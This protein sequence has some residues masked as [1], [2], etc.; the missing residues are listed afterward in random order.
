VHID[1]VETGLAIPAAGTGN[2]ELAGNIHIGIKITQVAWPAVVPFRPEAPAYVVDPFAVEIPLRP[3]EGKAV[4]G[5]L[6]GDHGGPQVLYPLL[7]NDIVPGVPVDDTKHEKGAM[8][9][10]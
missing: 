8:R 1:Q 2:L 4:R 3:S 9:R 5:E 6:Q 10:S 7:N